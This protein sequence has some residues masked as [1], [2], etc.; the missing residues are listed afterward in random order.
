MTKTDV[1]KKQIAFIKQTQAEEAEE[2]K[3]K[4]ELKS[5]TFGRKHKKKIA[6]VK[7]IGTGA[8]RIG[9]GLSILAKGIVKGARE[10]EGLKRQY[11]QMYGPQK[12]KIAIVKR[13]R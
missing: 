8:G 6:I 1:L 12:P 4:A 2:I 10:S 7:T 3:L 11:N 13:K 9:R 5:L